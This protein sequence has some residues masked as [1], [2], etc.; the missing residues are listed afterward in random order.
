[1]P[2]RKVSLNS[3]VA[4]LATAL[5]THAVGPLAAGARAATTAGFDGAGAF[6]T[7]TLT[8]GANRPGF[9]GLDVKPIRS[10]LAPPHTNRPIKTP[11]AMAPAACHQVRAGV[12][13]L[14]QAGMATT[15]AGAF[16]AGLGGAKSSGRTARGSSRMA[17]S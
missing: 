5:R 11:A 4:R 17:G 2:L 8:A 10:R 6:E 16:F 9:A 15:L 1:M 13:G 12:T 7:S 14:A 3:T